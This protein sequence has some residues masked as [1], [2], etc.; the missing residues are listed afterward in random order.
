V[1]SDVLS[2]PDVAIALW[3]VLDL[4]LLAQAVRTLATGNRSV[5]V[6]WLLIGFLYAAAGVCWWYQEQDETT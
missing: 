6:T 1:L 2:D 4:A 3:I 5:G